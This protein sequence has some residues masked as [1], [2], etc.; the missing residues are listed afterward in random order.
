MNFDDVLQ[1][2][3]KLRM[4]AMG[5]TRNNY[6][7]ADDL[8]QATLERAWRFQDKFKAEHEGS[9]LAWLRHIMRNCLIERKR[10]AYETS[11]T[12][13]N[14]A[15]AENLH[16]AYPCAGDDYCELQ[17]MLSAIGKLNGRG[18]ALL[19]TR[20]G[21]S[22][23]EVAQ[24]QNVRVGTIKSRVNRAEAELMEALAC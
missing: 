14:L 16:P 6:A 7:D 15:E 13:V 19:L 22:Y 9:L 3:P 5:L 20:M 23:A 2:S 24:L 12:L 18:Q 10:R 8:V 21:Y 4:T 1:L 11:T 17:E